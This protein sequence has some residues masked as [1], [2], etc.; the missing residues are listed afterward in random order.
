MYIAVV[1]SYPSGRGFTS[2]AATIKRWRRRRRTGEE[3][4]QWQLLRLPKWSNERVNQQD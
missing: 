1:S 3:E 2:G 4:K